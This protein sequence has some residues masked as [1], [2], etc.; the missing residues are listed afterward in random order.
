[1]YSPSKDNNEK[2]DCLS[3]SGLSRDKFSPVIDI[4]EYIEQH[5]DVLRERSV[6]FYSNVP[7]NLVSQTGLLRYNYENLRAA[8]P[9]SLFSC[10]E[11]TMAG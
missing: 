4:F 7:A 9:G 6:N 10:G 5:K 1:M 2:I 8:F 11:N 3:F